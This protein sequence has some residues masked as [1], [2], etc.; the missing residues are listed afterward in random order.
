MAKCRCSVAIAGASD[1]SSNG[2]VFAEIRLSS[3]RI[4]VTLA[5]KVSS[6]CWVGRGLGIY[7]YSENHSSASTTWKDSDLVTSCPS[8]FLTVG[9]VIILLIGLFRQLFPS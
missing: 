4:R 1:N 8:I 5:N 2:S 9:I 6:L 3:K 7:V